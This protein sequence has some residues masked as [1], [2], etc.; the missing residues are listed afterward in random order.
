MRAWIGLCLALLATG[1]GPVRAQDTP[2]EKTEIFIDNQRADEVVMHFALA[3]KTMRWKIIQQP[4]PPGEDLTYRFP[5]SLPACDSLEKLG[6]KG[7]V[8]VMVGSELIVCRQDIR[9]CNPTRWQAVVRDRCKWTEN[10]IF[11][12]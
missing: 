5:V 1:F 4:V 10:L 6:I 3:F 11:R 7:E 2:S 9:L 8:T 12:Q